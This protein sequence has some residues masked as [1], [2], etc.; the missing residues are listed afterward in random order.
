[1]AISQHGITYGRIPRPFSE[2]NK[3]VKKPDLHRSALHA[4]I[5]Y[6]IVG[7]DPSVCAHIQY[8]TEGRQVSRI[9]SPHST[10]KYLEA[11][12]YQSLDVYL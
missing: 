12:D 3:P 5:G 4:V 2:L 11:Q 9:I 1:M 7:K 6:F 10:Y 8:H